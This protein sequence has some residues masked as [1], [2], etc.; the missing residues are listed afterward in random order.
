MTA[1]EHAKL[2]KAEVAYCEKILPKEPN[3]IA[4]TARLGALTIAKSMARR[5]A[6]AAKEGS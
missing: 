1:E 2:W 5:Y 6:K 4:Y 3:D